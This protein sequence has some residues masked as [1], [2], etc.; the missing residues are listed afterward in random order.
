MGCTRYTID[1]VTTTDVFP[2]STTTY[3]ADVSAPDDNLYNP[4]RTISATLNSGNVYTRGT[5]STTVDIEDDEPLVSIVA[6]SNPAEPGTDGEFEIQLDKPA[7]QAFSIAYSIG[8]TATNND[9]YEALSGSV[10]V[11]PGDTSATILVEVFDDPELDPD[12]TVIVT[13]TPTT[14]NYSVESSANEATVTI[15]DDEIAPTA[16]IASVQ[17]PKED[18]PANAKFTIDLDN[19][20]LA[21]E[22]QGGV[23]GTFIYYSLTDG[24]ATAGDDY[25]TTTGKVFIPGG[26]D[27]VT[28][29][30]TVADDL[31]YES[32]GETFD[33]Q[34]EPHPDGLY[35]LG[36]ND[37]LTFT[38]EDDEEI[39]EATFTKLSDPAEAGSVAGQFRIDL[40]SVALAGG[41]TVGYEV[42]AAST[43]ATTDDYATLSGTV[44]IPEGQTQKTVSI[45]PVDDIAFDPDEELTIRLKPLTGELYTVGSSNN[46]V[47]FTIADND[48]IPVATLQ[49]VSDPTE[50]G[51]T[52]GEFEINLGSIALEGGVTVS[53]EVVSASTTAT[54]DDYAALAGSV[55]FPENT[56]QQTIQVVPTDDGLYDPGD[57]LTVKL[58]GPGS[59]LYDIGSA[60]TVTFTI[61]DND[62]LYQ[63][64]LTPE[65]NASEDGTLGYFLIELDQPALDTGLTV[66]Y[67]LSGGD[68]VADDDYVSVSGSV[69]VAPGATQAR[70]RVEAIDNPIDAPNRTL[71]LS[72]S[73]AAPGQIIE[74]YRNYTAD[75]SAQTA[76]IAIEDN[77]TAGVRLAALGNTTNETGTTAEIEIR[78]ESQPTD[79][80]TVEF[81]SSDTNEG[82]LDVASV[83]FD[84]SEWKT[85]KTV[86]VRGV[87]DGTIEDGDR[88]YSITPTV[89]SS[90]TAYDSLSLSPLNF[91]NLDND[92]YGLL[93]STPSRIGEGGTSSYTLALTQLPSEPIPVEI[94]ADD[95][96]EVSLDGSTFA[97]SV[98][99]NLSDT[100][101]KTVFVRAIDDSDVE[102][103]HNSTVTHRFLD[104]TDPN[105][106]TA[107][108]TTPAIV[109]IDDNDSP[110][111]GLVNAD[112]ATEQSVVSGRF[113][114]VLDQDAPA[115]G[116]T[117]AYQITAQTATSS[118]DYAVLSG[119]L[120]IPEG[121]TGGDIIVN[122]VQDSIVE[123][124]GET[125]TVQLIGGAGYSVDA[126]NASQT[127]SIF[128]DD[129]AGVRVRESGNASRVRENV[130]GD[131]YTLELTSQPSDP[132]IIDIDTTGEVTPNV[133]SV[134]FD[135][136][137]WNVP[138]TVQ[139]SMANNDVSDGDRTQVVAHSVS[140]ADGNYDGMAIDSVT[141]ELIDDDEPGMVMAETGF[142]TRV[143]EG[144]VT[145]SYTVVLESQPTD[146]VTVTVNQ[147]S[148]SGLEAIAPL[149]FTA[150][151]WSSPQT[152]NVMVD[153]DFIDRDDRTT[154]LTHT[155]SSADSNYDGWVL[156]DIEVAVTEDD[157]AGMTLTQSGGT[158]DITEGSID[159][160]YTIVLTSEPVELVTVDI[161][162]DGTSNLEAIDPLVFEPSE[163]NIPQTVDVT[164][165]NDDIDDDDRSATFQQTVTSA[166][167]KYDGWILDDVPVNITE[168]DFVGLTIQQTG[169]RNYVIEGSDNPDF[170][171]VIFNSQPISDVTIAFDTGTELEPIPD[172]VVTPS[173]WNTIFSI[174]IFAKQDAEFEATELVDLGFTVTSA[175]PKYDPTGGLTDTIPAP[176]PLV[177]EVADRQLVGSETA[178]GLEV[179]IDRFETMFVENLRSQTFPFLADPVETLVPDLFLFKERLLADLAELG[180]T[181]ATTASNTIVNALQESFEEA[182]IDVD[183][184]I[185]ENV[186][187]EEITF[188][189][190]MAYR[191]TFKTPIN[192]NLGLDE[193]KFD[194]DGDFDGSFTADLTFGLGWHENFG[195]YID[196]DKTQF[197]TTFDV[198]PSSGFKAE[199]GA[200][201]LG[202]KATNDTTNPT[203]IDIDYNLSLTDLDDINQIRFLDA[204]NNGSWDAIEPLVEQQDNGSF[205]ALPI[206]GRFDLDGSGAYEEPTEGT[207]LT[208]D[209][210]DDGNR[211]TLTELLENASQKELANGNFTGTHNLGL[212]LDTAIPGLRDAPIPRFLFALDADWGALTY[213]RDSDS[214]QPLQAIPNV[215]FNNF[216]IDVSSIGDFVLPIF[217]GI[218]PFLEP[219]EFFADLLDLNIV[220]DPIGDL[221]DTF[222]IGRIGGIDVT[223]FNFENFL[224]GIADINVNL[225][226]FKLGIQDF[227]RFP[228]LVANLPTGFFNFGSFQILAPEL[229]ELDLSLPDLNL[230]RIPSPSLN[231][232]S[233][234]LPE[235][236]GSFDISQFSN[237]K[238]IKFPV[239]TDPIQGLYLILGKEDVTL[240]TLE[241][242]KI[243]AS[244]SLDTKTSIFTSFLDFIPDWVEALFSSVGKFEANVE[245]DFDL[246]AGMGFGFDTWGLFKWA[247]TD[248]DPEQADL[249]LDGFF[250]SDRANPDGTGKDVNELYT[251]LNLDIGLEAGSLLS[252]SGKGGL[253]GN[254]RVDLADPNGDG[255][256]RFYSEVLPQIDS[257]NRLI[258]ASGKVSASGS[259]T[260][261]F[262]ISYPSVPDFWNTDTWSKD[263]YK[264]KLPRTDL[265]KFSVGKDGV[266]VGTAFDG[267]IEGADVFFDANFNGVQDDLEPSTITFG[268]GDYNLEIPL[269][270]FDVNGD[271]E[272]DLREGQIVVENG[273]DT[274]TFDKQRFPFF[275]APEWTVA[276]PLTML[277][278]R[279]AQPDLDAIEAQL[280]RS[281]SLPSGFDLQEGNPFVAIEEGDRTGVTVLVA[282]GQLQNL[283]ILG[284]NALQGEGDRN[285]AANALLAQ[286][287][288][289]VQSGGSLN[290]TDTAQITALIS[291]AASAIGSGADITEV[292]TDIQ[293]RN[294][295]IVEASSTPI[296]EVREAIVSNIALDAIDSSYYNI[297]VD[298]W[299]VLLGNATPIPDSEGAA[300]RVLDAFDLPNVD[301]GSFDPFEAMESGNAIGLQVYAKQVQINATLTQVADIA[302]GLGVENAEDLVVTK[303][304]D[305]LYSGQ[306]LADMGNVEIIETLLRSTASGLSGNLVSAMAQIVAQG[307]TD[308]DELVA[309]AAESGDLEASRLGIIDRQV[310]LQ[311]VQAQLLQS[312]ASGEI[313]ISLFDRL[314]E[315]NLDALNSSSLIENILEGTDGDDTLTGG[316]LNDWIDG[317]AG[318]DLLQGNGGDDQLYGREGNDILQGGEGN[319]LLQGG[320]NEDILQ[321]GD[322]DDFGSGNEGNDVIEAGDGDDNFSGG[323]GNDSILG[324]AGDDLLRG[325][326]GVDTL[327]GGD[328]NDF[329]D[330]G[331]DNDEVYGDAGDDLIDGS[332]GDDL[333]FGGEDDDI[334][335]GGGGI[336]N[337]QGDAG[338]DILFGNKQEDLLVGGE[339]NDTLAAGMQNDKVVGGL[340]DDYVFGN[341]QDDIVEG[342]EGNDYL[343]GGQDN[344]V[345]YGQVGDDTL[346]GDM[347]DD[348]LVGGEGVNRF[349]FGKNSG[350]D[351][352]ADFKDGIDAIALPQELLAEVQ[353]RTAIATNV[354][355]GAPW[356][357]RKLLKV[358]E[359]VDLRKRG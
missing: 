48:V 15:A 179:V 231:L 188:D 245:A 62:H 298:P 141:V 281:F 243:E 149:V 309:E 205:P 279:M 32:G 37:S 203:A 215:A 118:T 187:L 186:D 170:I 162:I 291:N 240:A 247:A 5:S 93:V 334:L 223:P 216:G 270:L 227:L 236:S 33:V 168:D 72:L 106:P 339:G 64:R 124:G 249:V 45:S 71:E 184:T 297:A 323:E 310:I 283:L 314:M 201:L 267:L 23:N 315:F 200:G 268:E 89:S 34:L 137:N 246:R 325:D 63:V 127:V 112:A 98:V 192:P 111:A 217:E 58:T 326:T 234:N 130:S 65:A 154:T 131:S 6:N 241:T 163:W 69:T 357:C 8:G 66:D 116:V 220:P 302:I 292:V 295:A 68:A 79:P 229:P 250:V 172:L 288:Q 195:F 108:E 36:T 266:S 238:S 7:P 202:G 261:K 35:V 166:D 324:E 303:F 44:T 204:N 306:S 18:G 156:D 276:S 103:R 122:P 171:E 144:S 139:L 301:L 343:G 94:L 126:G 237:K 330:A 221:F 225:G 49:K 73:P 230:P 207:I 135:A 332:D 60:D 328:G 55:T 193:L 52:P 253:G 2:H 259:A 86:T 304:L 271:G 355:G 226:D 251:N 95:Q 14:T 4:G 82:D 282:Q 10:S 46:E 21:T 39:P 206:F 38:I 146:D 77:D 176:P 129:I 317:F 31:E 13:L 181:D 19:P 177:I 114:V 329:I 254:L 213:D 74:P 152:V 347:G 138:Q 284:S 208:T 155:V 125:I 128:D 313:D 321:G 150:S 286:V 157:E 212:N 47:T 232:G 252:V 80:V 42:V 294:Q 318:N 262:E 348:L 27:S 92:G 274:D 113:G 110:I 160:S 333:I 25:T 43:T 107:A 322:G 57:T 17:T 20:A 218:G 248:F 101:N 224:E 119:S 16:T 341:K 210:P 85:A 277:A 99:A 100:S 24:T 280:K 11:A 41:V 22:I 59:E 148:D 337:L 244:G 174:P 196:S 197:N 307:N 3:S 1:G 189:I 53:Y 169:S 296:E 165:I 145:D 115:G 235:V 183:L 340:G 54:S 256:V 81:A 175:D 349:R 300:D 104:H 258:S 320:E 219:L 56:T 96:T 143:T 61:T 26:D 312:V 190:G 133:T 87:D 161:T 117:I 75:S 142:S 293:T 173:E 121:A 233:V 239:L 198:N 159:D 40:S 153:D 263:L 83:T 265:F 209:K 90:D 70:I 164:L 327:Y 91:T 194:L 352:V 275:T 269:D 109:T 120:F 346:S 30:V 105:Y 331:Q 299:A 167:P 12:E 350:N 84:P 67:T 285:A 336:D 28:I 358:R 257:L 151:N 242:P 199:G 76:V 132:V 308:I 228:D 273:T 311:G 140:S 344:D 222:D 272:I 319:D 180:A 134:T 264:L 29:E 278:L 289:L 290:L 102:G 147:A 354:A 351:I 88:P 185:Q 338:N 255:K 50:E 78:L 345:L 287:G 335:V 316:D 9:D 51:E 158:T 353:S 136:N 359:G 182:G 260:L 191:D 214:L 356:W 178:D 123:T 97:T 305:I 342:G 211:L